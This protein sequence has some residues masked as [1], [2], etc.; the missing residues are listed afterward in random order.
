M[1]RE[2]R[3]SEGWG[4]ARTAMK[5]INEPNK[6]TLARDEQVIGV[7]R[8]MGQGLWLQRGLG[9][10]GAG[11]GAVGECCG[12]KGA[13]RCVTMVLQAG[14]RGEGGGDAGPFLRA[15]GGVAASR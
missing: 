4:V 13:P 1:P 12:C 10:A 2:G 5:G 6:L 14:C 8:H 7:Q 15:R 9:E 11:A 3:S